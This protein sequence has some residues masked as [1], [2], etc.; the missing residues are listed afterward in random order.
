[1]DFLSR[2]LLLERGI[3]Y[4]RCVCVCVLV[5]FRHNVVD[6]RATGLTVD[7]ECR[8]RA[9]RDSPFTNPAHLR[10]GLQFLE[11]AENNIAT[12]LG[13]SSTF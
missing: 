7:S 3:P 4:A 6:I 1:M 11:V 2:T 13:I 10:Q 8:G 9:V 12:I 5:L